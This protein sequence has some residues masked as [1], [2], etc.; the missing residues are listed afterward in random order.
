MSN[1]SSLNFYMALTFIPLR[2]SALLLV[3]LLVD[4]AFAVGPPP[5]P[6]SFSLNFSESWSGFP[7]SPNTGAWLYDY[8]NQ[9]WRADHNAP[10]N[11]NFCSCADNATSDSCSLIFVPNGPAGATDPR[12]A[13]GGMFVD[14]PDKPE[15][16]CWL[17]GKDDGCSPLTPDWLSSG[18]YVETGVDTGGCDIFCIPGASATADCLSYPPSSSSSSSSSSSKGVSNASIPC[19]YTENFS[20]SGTAIVHNLTFHKETFVPGP[21]PRDV[22]NVRAECGKPCKNLFPASCG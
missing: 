17:C 20:F 6:V 11:N 2:L 9:L 12:I 14:F 13:A 18:P 8:P 15:E 1:L 21:P 10:Q 19:L 5:L 16:C 4:Q 22:F 3:V 7:A